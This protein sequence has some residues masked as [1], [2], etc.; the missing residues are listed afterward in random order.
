MKIATSI[1]TILII[2]TK[3]VKVELGLKCKVKE[4]FNFIN[5]Y[6]IL[7]LLKEGLRNLKVVPFQLF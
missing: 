2:P 6:G 4:L 3:D 1:L 7:N 5:F